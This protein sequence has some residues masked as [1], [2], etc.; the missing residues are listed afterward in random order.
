MSHGYTV[1]QTAR[2]VC[3][4][5]WVC[6]RLS[7]TAGGWA[8]EAAAAA[9]ARHSRG[10]ASGPDGWSGD[11]PDDGIAAAAVCMAGMSR[12]LASHR[13]ALDSLQPDSE[14]LASWRQ[15][16]PATQPL[17][18]AFD[19]VAALDGPL[20]RLAVVRG[21]L[22]PA[23]VDAYGE[24]CEHAASHCDAALA[25]VARSL[26]HD[27]GRGCVDGGPAHARES[28]STAV[29]EAH[30]ALSAAGGMVGRSLLRPDDW[31]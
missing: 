11:S 4:L 7:E 18:A 25:S 26:R 24:I 13:E 22:V 2:L 15:A 14:R 30:E 10:G 29:A 9:G 23:L 6:G 5:R 20:D 19:E 17:A 1:A 21:V 3:A 12:R 28:R 16:A 8:A 27:L 31:S